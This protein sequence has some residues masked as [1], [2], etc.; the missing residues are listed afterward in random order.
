MTKRVTVNLA[1]FTQY[2]RAAQRPPDLYL[3]PQGL[4]T[5]IIGAM[6]VGVGLA[7]TCGPDYAFS[8]LRLTARDGRESDTV[9]ES[10]ISV[11]DFGAWLNQDCPAPARQQLE[12]QFQRL[13]NPPAQW[14]GL[15]LTRPLVMGIVNVTPDSFSDGGD[16]AESQGAIAHGRLLMD[17]GADI[18]DIGG[19][20]TRP[21][22]KPVSPE[23]ESSRVV[24]VVTALAREGATVSID[25]RHAAVMAAALDAGAR[26]INDVSALQGEGALELAIARKAPVV[27]M[28]MPGDPQTMQG[29]AR[30]QDPALDVW[31]FLKSRLDAW[32]AAGGSRE[33]VV[34]DPGIGFGKTTEHNL[35]ILGRLSLY[36]SLGA[37]ILLGVSRKRLIE[38]ILQSSLPAK[39]RF[40]GSLAL[41]L[42]GASQGA[43]ILRVH[44][45]AETIQGLRSWQAVRRQA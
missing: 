9:S 30:Y 20:S 16:H 4:L 8:L 12:R 18:I 1:G 14:A 21:G 38:Q 37:G 17:A 45:V 6:A 39:R 34:I 2:L 10:L 13:L 43:N 24:P 36:R 28:H 35:Q 41:A 3:A 42:E 40:P 29:L 32:E 31:D 19:E 5:G 26:I 44:D 7:A 27:L 11:T 33:D 23:V 15:S 25:T 22:A